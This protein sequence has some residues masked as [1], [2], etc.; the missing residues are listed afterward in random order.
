[1]FRTRRGFMACNKLTVC[2]VTMDILFEKYK[3]E[4]GGGRI[5]YEFD[6]LC[7][8]NRKFRL[9]IWSTLTLVM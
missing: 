7:E 2:L 9:L 1:M 8:G 5:D 3:D 6:I 4:I